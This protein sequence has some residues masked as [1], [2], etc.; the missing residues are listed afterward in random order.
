MNI[1]QFTDVTDN[2]K[3]YKYKILVYPNIT[4]LKDLEKDSFVVVL[5]NII[6]ELNK[7]RNDLHFTIIVPEFVN[8]LKFY[9]KEINQLDI[10]EELLAT[11][12][13]RG[14]KF[15]KFKQKLG[16]NINKIGSIRFS[17][18]KNNKNNIYTAS[19][20]CDYIISGDSSSE[21]SSFLLHKV[22]WKGL[23]R[24]YKKILKLI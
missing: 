7:I 20:V 1:F 21:N 13:Q 23:K 9:A 6:R 12:K 18:E 4:Y 10:L 2:D 16:E 24:R 22:E 11:P 15:L 5:G 19:Q 14:K 3:E 17:C 8:S